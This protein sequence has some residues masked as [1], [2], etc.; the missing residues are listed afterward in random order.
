MVTK[1]DGRMETVK[2]NE[3]M[4]LGTIFLHYGHSINTSVNVK[5]HRERLI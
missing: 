5:L 4:E 3:S 1:A 2:S